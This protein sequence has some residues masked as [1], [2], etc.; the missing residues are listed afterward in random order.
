MSTL[1]DDYNSTAASLLAEI[2]D[3]LLGGKENWQVL[4]QLQ[5]ALIAKTGLERLREV[6]DDLFPTTASAIKSIYTDKIHEQLKDAAT[7]NKI[8][9]SAGYQTS[10]SVKPGGDTYTSN[11]ATYFH[12][13]LPKY[14]GAKGDPG[15][16]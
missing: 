12:Q 5:Q 2:A 7:F 15:T 8:M 14:Y 4:E 16:A 13:V 11:S 3:A 9:D 6:N 1:S 10:Y